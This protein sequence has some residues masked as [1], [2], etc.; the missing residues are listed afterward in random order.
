MRRARAGLAILVA[1]ACGAAEAYVP[2]ATAVLKRLSQKR[3]EQALATLE[4]QGTVTFL[5]EAA[6]RAA[7]LG[8][9]LLGT[10]ASSPAFL[11]VKVAGK[12]RLELALPEAAPAERPAVS[13]KGGRLQGARGLEKLPAAVAALQAVC[14]LLGERPGGAEPERP[15][16][17]ALTG[18]GVSLEETSLGRTGGRVAYVIGGKPRDE[19][20]LAWIDKQG[21]QPLR[22]SATLG[23]ARHEVRFLDWG[24]P[25]GGDLFPRALEV[26]SG[27]QPVLRLVTE[28]VLGNPKV[29]DAIF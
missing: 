12:C 22:L 26:I 6:Q 11:T 1:L 16:V 2:P 7:A 18:L 4:V 17:Q 5:G 27:G 23:G 25:T 8:L 13:Q 29:S 10:E 20:P 19:K 28:R 21:L 14:A 24:S 9:A 3:E 15:W